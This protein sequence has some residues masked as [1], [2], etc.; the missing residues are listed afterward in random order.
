EGRV[1]VPVLP[2]RRPHRLR[3][4]TRH[5]V[6]TVALELLTVAAVDQTPV[7]PRL[8]DNRGEI[9]HAAS[10]SFA[11]TEATAAGASSKAAPADR[12][13]STV[14]ARIWSSISSS[15]RMRPNTS[16]DRAI[17]SARPCA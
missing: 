10:A 2:R 14:T 9:V 8:G 3:L 7:G 11:P 4:G 6:G 12:A 17:W 1:G 15:P 5:G 16:I 13:C